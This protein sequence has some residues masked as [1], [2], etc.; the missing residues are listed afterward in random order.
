VVIT[1]TQKV[2]EIISASDYVTGLIYLILYTALYLDV[3]N[4]VSIF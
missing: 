1:T 4:D 2:F 3:F